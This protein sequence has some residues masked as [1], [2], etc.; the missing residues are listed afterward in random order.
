MISWPVAWSRLPVGSS[1]RSRSGWA[2]SARAMAARCIS[3]PKARGAVLQPVARPTI[4]SSRLGRCPV[5]SPM[6]QI[7]PDAVGNHQRREHVFQRRQF[8]QEVVELENHAELRF[9][10]A[11]RLGGGQIVDPPAVRNGFRP[12]RARRACPAGAAACSCPSR[13]GRRSPGTRRGGRSC[14]RRGAPGTS[15][16]PLR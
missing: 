14:S 6:P 16:A 4:S 10:R 1:A 11:S 5:F 13:F 9:R 15:T 7:A 3:P 12:G 8:G 2:T